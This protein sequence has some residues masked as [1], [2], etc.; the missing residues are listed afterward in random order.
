MVKAI[1]KYLPII[2][3]IIVKHGLSYLFPLILQDKGKDGYSLL[4]NDV[5]K[6]VPF[7]FKQY[8]RFR[9]LFS[10]NF[11]VEMPAIYFYCD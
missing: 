11:W 1:V 4:I 8:Y 5:A 3:Y 2:S 7:L 6:I 9:G 10:L